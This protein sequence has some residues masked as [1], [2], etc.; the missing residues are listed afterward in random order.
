MSQLIQGLD[1]QY[2]H[3][4]Y[5]REPGGVLREVATTPPGFL[6]DEDVEHLG[7]SLKLPPWEEQRRDCIKQLLEPITIWLGC[8]DG[9]PH[10]P[11]HRV[12]DS[13]AIFQ[14]MGAEVDERIYPNGPHT[15]YKDEIE[16][17]RAILAR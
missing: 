10:V 3:S 5:F 4:I 2:F 8:S 12:R 16:G 9:D 14:E 17:A 1:R 11:L 13:S 6:Y 15:I 7:Q